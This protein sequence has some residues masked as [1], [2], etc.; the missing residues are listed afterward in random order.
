MFIRFS[1]STAII[2]LNSFTR[3]DFATEAGGAFSVA[4]AEFKNIININ[5]GLQSNGR[6]M[7]FIRESGISISQ[8]RG[9]ENSFAKKLHFIRVNHQLLRTVNLVRLPNQSI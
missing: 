5:L 1:E 4:E 8:T 6:K 3:L 7:L 9:K 2:S